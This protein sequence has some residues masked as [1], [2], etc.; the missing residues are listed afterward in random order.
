LPIIQKLTVAYA[1]WHGY[2]IHFDKVSRYSIGL[3]IDMLFIETIK[4]VFVATHKSRDQKIVYLNTASDTLD[5]LK[6]M[7]QIVWHIRIID[8]NKYIG[9]SKE[10]DEIGKMLGGWLKQ[11]NTSR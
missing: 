3:K 10:L 8:N 7:L 6:F 1:L 4:N 11:T 5:L 9:L 2:V